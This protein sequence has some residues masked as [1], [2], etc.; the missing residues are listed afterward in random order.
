MTAGEKERGTMQ[1]L[2]CAPVRATEIIVGK[3]L[4][5]WSIALIAAVANV[6]S[7]GMTLARLLPGQLTGAPS[8]YLLTF[9]LLLPVTLLF[10]A[11]FLA[12]AVF[13]KDFKDAQNFL[14]PIYMTLGLPAGV[15]MLPGQELSAWTAFVPVVNIALLIKAVFLGDAA[16]DLI[17][18]VL[19]SSVLYAAL[20]M[21]LAARVFEREQILLGGGDSWR[22]V[23]SIERRAGGHPTPVTGLLLFAIV[24]VA[25]FYGSLFLERFGMV[26]TLLVVELGFF[27]APA[28]GAAAIFGYDWRQ[29][30]ALRRPAALA[31]AGAVLIG[32]G[33]WTVAGGILIRLLPPPESLARAMEKLLL[34]DGQPVPLWIVWL[35]IGVTP[36]VCEELFF[37]GF[38]MSGLR[39]TGAW[40]AALISALLFGV[41]HASIYRLMPTLFLGILFGVLVWRTGSIVCSIVAHALNNSLMATIVHSKAVADWLGVAG[42][43]FL[44]WD[45]TIAGTVVTAIG[46]AL[47]W[48]APSRDP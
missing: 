41:A 29:T 23:F 6:A 24:M 27:L 4:A 12:V 40:P 46:V 14:T 13:A 32:L 44:R 1:T 2:M 16:P 35:A 3:F 31:L 10:T 42:S 25:V 19:L 47:I 37:R 30:F 36:A 20:A 34:L 11:I 48:R 28:L 39:S 9:V 15:T 33:A 8:S 7:L 18:L 45:L 5:V 17:F 21:M 22:A 38:V 43:E 26:A